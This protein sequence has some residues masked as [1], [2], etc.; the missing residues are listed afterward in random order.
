MPDSKKKAAPVQKDIEPNIAPAP[1][2][3]MARE[4]TVIDES[5][6]T[7]AYYNSRVKELGIRERIEFLNFRKSWSEKLLI[8]V[9]SIVIFNAA[10]LLLV[11]FG[12]LQFEDEWL[13]RIIIT[14]GFLEVLGLAKIV[15]EFL[16]KDFPAARDIDER[17]TKA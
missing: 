6:S 17:S 15:V 8:L 7:D 5:A 3:L 16:F 1:F 9:I 2:S 14:G 10:F 13:V 12:I 11:G 4:N